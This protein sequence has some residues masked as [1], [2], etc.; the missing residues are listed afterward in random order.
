[1]KSY[2]RKTR[3]VPLPKK[4]NMTR[5][6]TLAVMLVTT[7]ATFAQK[8]VELEPRKYLSKVVL[9]GKKEYTYYALSQTN[10]TEYVVKGP[11]KLYLNFRARIVDN[12]FQSQPFRV[13]YLR[14][15]NYVQIEQ[16]P[17]LSAGNLKF[18]SKSLTGSPTKLHRI[19]VDVPPG[20]H[21]YRFYKYNTDQRT[22][23][24]VFYEKHPDP[25]W[26]DLNPSPALEK[27][28]V[29]FKKSG[30]TKTYHRITKA[31]SFEFRVTDSARM[32]VIVRPEFTYRMLNETIVRVRLTNTST[33]EQK[34][35]KINARKSGS[36]E[37]VND[38]KNTPG[39]SS[40][41]YLNL[42]KPGGTQ[43]K[44]SLSLVGGAKAVVIRIS[45]D[46]NLGKSL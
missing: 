15:S 26:T 4:R 1:M 9:V 20:K 8:K 43:D 35:Y 10:R 36:L 19:V 14:S 29:R 41:F 30:K 42:P 25:K 28:D 18:K 37:F 27:K 44:Y 6:L 24:R 13:K 11:G 3:S 21:T 38:K 34:T 7:S 22:H 16:V 39:N 45:N 33:G 31:K 23:M 40:T 12:G 17:S 32:R 46:T 5:T 2:T